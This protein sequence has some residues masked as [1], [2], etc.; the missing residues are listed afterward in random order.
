LRERLL[1]QANVDPLVLQVFDQLC[2][3]AEAFERCHGD[4]GDAMP[5]IIRGESFQINQ[6]ALLQSLQKNYRRQVGTST[7]S[8]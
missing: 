2:R 3:N 1:Q 5:D 8:G 7:S 6:V 4:G